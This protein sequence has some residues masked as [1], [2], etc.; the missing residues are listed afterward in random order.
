[1][2]GLSLEIPNNSKWVTNKVISHLDKLK[3]VPKKNLS[4]SLVA[5][6]KASD[7]SDK[8]ITLATKKMN[9][10][11]KS[12]KKQ[13]SSQN[14][15]ERQ[16]VNW[17]NLGQIK[18]FWKEKNKEVSAKKLY[19]KADWTPAQRRLAE[20][21]L[22]LAL[23]GGSGHPPP[24]LEFSELVYTTKNEF[25][26]NKNYLYQSK[27]GIWRT[28]VKKSKVTSKKGIIDIKLNSPVARILNR[29]KKFLS[30][31]R[32]VFQNKKGGPLSKS[33]YSKRLRAL[34]AERFPKKRIGAGL[35]RTIFL[36]DMYKG[37]PQLKIQEQTAKK[38]FHNKET[39][40]SKYV[41][42]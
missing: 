6:L 15:T 12:V 19:S 42:K 2:A 27:R 9:S 17:V 21:S 41:K 30:P 34:F 28:R 33:A 35:I 26:E 29:M 10:S 7:A 24:R 20:Q 1:M 11:A 8:V 31:G 23:H 16:K 38:M 4:A 18:E 22:M 3:S 5:Y 40:M 32:P 14:K 36:S 25:P 39:A 13:Y 37:M